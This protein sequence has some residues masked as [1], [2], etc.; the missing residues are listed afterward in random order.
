MSALVGVFN[1]RDERLH[2]F[3]RSVADVIFERGRELFMQCLFQRQL[4]V[5]QVIEGDL[6]NVFVMTRFIQ[7]LSELFDEALPASAHPCKRSN[8]R[9][10]PRVRSTLPASISCCEWNLSISPEPAHPAPTSATKDVFPHREALLEQSRHRSPRGPSGVVKR[11]LHLTAS[12]SESS[13]LCRQLNW[14]ML[15]KC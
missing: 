13:S 8:S 11:K 15:A 12:N 9:F 14:N 6:V 4:C 10:V 1:T 2:F 7:H 3:R 5:G